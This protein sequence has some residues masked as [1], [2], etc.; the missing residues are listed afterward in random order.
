MAGLAS[1]RPHI[2]RRVRH[3]R[4]LFRLLLPSLR[5]IATIRG[6]PHR[7]AQQAHANQYRKESVQTHSRE[8]HRRSLPH[9]F[10][11]NRVRPVL[12][13]IFKASVRLVCHFQYITLFFCH[14][15]RVG[16]LPSQIAALVAIVDVSFSSSQRRNRKPPLTRSRKEKG[17]K[18]GSTLTLFVTAVSILCLFLDYI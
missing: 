4:I 5:L 13:S 8:T 3:P 12:V 11:R 1:L 9:P 7:R 6:C 15:E 16:R 18:G 2:L 10:V 14:N 17:W